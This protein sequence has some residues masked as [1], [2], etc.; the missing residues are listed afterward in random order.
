[1]TCVTCLRPIPDE[2]LACAICTQERSA[3]ALRKFQYAPLRTVIAGLGQLTTRRIE[4]IRHVQMFGADQ[5]YC[6][7]PVSPQHPRSRVDYDPAELSRVCS[8]CRS[9]L[10][11]LIEE[12]RRA[13]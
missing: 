11:E 5:T 2:L 12:A 7:L 13:G 1:M 4:Q 6:G 10:D 8:K 3:R 9:Q